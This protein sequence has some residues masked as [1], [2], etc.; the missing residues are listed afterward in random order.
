MLQYDTADVTRCIVV[1]TLLLP[2]HITRHGVVT[3]YRTPK[4]VVS[5]E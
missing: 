4:M 2:Y 1:A 3:A 5:A